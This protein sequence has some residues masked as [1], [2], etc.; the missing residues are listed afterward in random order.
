LHVVQYTRDPVEPLCNEGETIAL[1]GVLLGELCELLAIMLHLA[2]L[3]NELVREHINEV[4]ELVPD[5]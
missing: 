3:A 2:D 5:S 1:L 4:T